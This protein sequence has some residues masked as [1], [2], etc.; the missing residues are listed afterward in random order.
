M[1]STTD[2]Q[3]DQQASPALFQPLQIRGLHLRNRIVVSPMGMY[4]ST[5]GHFTDF[6]LMHHGHFAFRGAALSI[7]EV[8]A[9][10]PNGRS[11][12][13]DAGL[14]DDA[15]IEGAKKVVDFVHGL[16]GGEA[17]IGIQLGHAGRKA[18]MMPIYPGQPV[19]RVAQEEGGWQ[20][21]VWGASAVPFMDNYVKPKEM[22]IQN[23]KEVVR[24]FG[25][26]ATRA[27]KAGFD[28]IE[29]HA[30]HGYLL[31]SFLSPAANLRTDA[32]GGSFENR[33]RFLLEVVHEIRRHIP[34]SIAFSVRI[35]AVDWMEHSP[36]TP[37]WRLEDSIKLALILSDL[38]VDILDVSSGGNNAAQ[39]ISTSDVYY[40]I[41]LAEKIKRAL[42]DSG[43]GMLVAA[44]GR[45]DNSTI[46]EALLDKGTADLALVATQF[47]RDPNLVYKWADELGAELK[48]PRQY[49]RASRRAKMGT[50]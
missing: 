34:D 46:A 6:H 14:W 36:E 4:S 21:E 15:Q 3:Q 2:S 25:E 50:L 7:V 37:Q 24:S 29:I 47:L 39:Q 30:A 38:G 20:D 10:L 16:E 9:V 44:V 22:T 40:Q 48:W 12:P 32:Y 26:A 41:D 33:I 27:V 23:I 19:V 28:F 49:V 17:K 8:T 45:I 1:P 35:S 5:N 18:S 11:S 42:Q 13:N 31:S 43:K